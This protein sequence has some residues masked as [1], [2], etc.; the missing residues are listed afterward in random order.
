MSTHRLFFCLKTLEL[1][2]V[3]TFNSVKQVILRFGLLAIALLIL[4]QLGQFSLFRIGDREEWQIALFAFL[5]ITFGIYIARYINQKKKNPPLPEGE[6]DQEM[7][8]KLGI[9]KRE[10][11]VLALVKEGYSNHEIAIKLYISE[12]TVKSHVSNLLVKLDAKRRTQAIIK[13]EELHI[14]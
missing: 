12:S 4:L 2:N 11:E 8:K 3:F 1:S 5:F 14:I 10:Y 6:I 9:S 7:I 13:A